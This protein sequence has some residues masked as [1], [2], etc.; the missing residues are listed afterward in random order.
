MAIACSFPEARPLVWA[1]GY[2][3]FRLAAAFTDWVPF[4]VP[5]DPFAVCAAGLLCSGRA[6]PLSAAA[7]LLAGL[8]GGDLAG[9][10]HAAD[11]T[12]RLLGA[13]I[14]LAAL[15]RGTD[16]LSATLFLSFAHPVWSAL[17][18]EFR[19]EF[20]FPYLYAVHL[21]QSLLFLGLLIPWLPPA[22]FRPAPRLLTALPLPAAVLLLWHFSPIPF[23]PLPRLGDASGTAVRIFAVFLTLPPL[24][25]PLWTL[26]S[27]IH[28]QAPAHLTEPPLK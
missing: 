27:K 20:P 2:A 1:A 12:V 14:L 22:P 21:T 16:A 13:A 25:P 5:V 18:P 26:R 4:T 7:V 28:C 9:G 3:L 17:C 11:V 10:L 6:R 19:G 24:I 8:A 15:P 23:W